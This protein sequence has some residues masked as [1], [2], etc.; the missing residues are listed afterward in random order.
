MRIFLTQWVIV[1]LPDYCAVN[2]PVA[3]WSVCRAALL[4]CAVVS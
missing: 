3:V 2:Q 4:L 1:F